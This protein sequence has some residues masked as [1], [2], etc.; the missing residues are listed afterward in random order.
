LISCKGKV[1]IFGHFEGDLVNAQKANAKESLKFGRLNRIL[2]D[3]FGL[4]FYGFDLD[5]NGFE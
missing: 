4:E 5:L 1:T 2:V 3:T